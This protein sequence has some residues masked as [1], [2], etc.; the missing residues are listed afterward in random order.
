MA[1]VGLGPSLGI[2]SGR[3]AAPG[4]R[5]V[6]ALP[7]GAAFARNSSGTYRDA[8]G[9]LRS[10]A[11]DVPRFDHR[12]AGDSWSPAGL[13][14]EPERTNRVRN[15]AASGATAGVANGYPDLWWISALPD[16][17]SWESL[18]S[19]SEDGLPWFAL[20]VHG[21][22]NG[23]FEVLLDSDYLS[24]APGET[25]T[26]SVFCVMAAGSS[27]GV[28]AELRLWG[29][30][31][32]VDNGIAP[33][34]LPAGGPLAATLHVLT[35][36][37]ADPGLTGISPRIGIAVHGAVDVTLRIAAPQ[38]ERGDTATSPILTTGAAAT[39]SADSL[40]LD[41]GGAGI[42]DGMHMISYL[43]VAGESIAST[44]IEAGSAAVPAMTDPIGS[45][46]CR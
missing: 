27:A 14:V 7:P 17:L 24:A 4:F 23:S 41:W 19:G 22:A 29:T 30:P 15:A 37:F 46:L 13:L 35:H 3:R 9:V 2:G 42:A 25:H 28:A 21:S 45:A 20:R 18:G 16:G 12:P 44:S 31:A 43:T 26:L 38:V 11:S 6:Q 1:A 36:R 32:F 34:T 39:R 10:A 40:T 33:M 8:A 5:L